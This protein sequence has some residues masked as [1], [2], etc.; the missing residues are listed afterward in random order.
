[1]LSQIWC[2]PIF[3]GY[4]GGGEFRVKKIKVAQNSLKHILVLEFLR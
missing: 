2:Y 4:G 1:M 3:N